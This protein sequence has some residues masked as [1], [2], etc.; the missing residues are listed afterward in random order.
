MQ[1]GDKAQ[2][3]FETQRIRGPDG[4][5]RLHALVFDT[6]QES[7][8]GGA[9]ADYGA[10]ASSGDT[11]KIELQFVE[12]TIIPPVAPS[13]TS[14]RAIEA[15]AAKGSGSQ[16]KKFFMQQGVAFKTGECI[17]TEQQ[18]MNRSSYSHVRGGLDFTVDFLYDMKA[19]LQLRGV[20]PYS[21]DD[22]AAPVAPKRRRTEAHGPGK[23]PSGNQVTEQ[24][25]LTG[26]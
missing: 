8:E 1:S 23:L 17:G 9:T 16:D 21:D 25:D 12:V 4:V 18:H 19:F 22:E 10:T 14:G 7:K 24:V 13:A 5:T 15:K 6:P 20:V 2:H 26:E 3:K 11:G